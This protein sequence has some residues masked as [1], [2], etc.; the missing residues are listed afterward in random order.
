MD[1]VDR[2]NV[3]SEYQILNDAIK[4]AIRRSASSVVMLGH[5][6]R[7]MMDEKLWEGHYSSLD[8]YL[9]AELHMD[10]TMACRFEAIN[11]KYSIGGRSGHI[12]EKWEDY[13]QGVL[14]EM[15]NM[16]PELEAE[17]TPEARKVKWAK[18]QAAYAQADLRLQT[19]SSIDI[20]VD[21]M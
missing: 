10:Y 8:D 4:D 18:A 16:P 2:L 14:I 1:V 20:N 3:R 9:R 5:M 15:L 21:G 19:V 12:D 13:S 11:R 6:L 17:V 7:R